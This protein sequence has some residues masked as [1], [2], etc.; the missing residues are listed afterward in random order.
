MRYYWNRSYYTI[1]TNPSTIEPTDFTQ[2]ATVQLSNAPSPVPTASPTITHPTNAPIPPAKSSPNGTVNITPPP[3]EHQTIDNGISYNE[4][5]IATKIVD[6]DK[7][8]FNCGEAGNYC[9]L[10]GFQSVKGIL[11]NESNIDIKTYFYVPANVNTSDYFL[12]NCVWMGSINGNFDNGGSISN[13][14]NILSFDLIMKKLSAQDQK[15]LMQL[16]LILNQVM[17]KDI[18]VGFTIVD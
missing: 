9:V 4:Q 16:I 6:I 10:L 1:I 13:I 14:V 18:M 15:N 12:I 8:R 3:T 2:N 11:G 5:I 7:A 17:E